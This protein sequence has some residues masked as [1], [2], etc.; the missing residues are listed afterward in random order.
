MEEE[1]RRIITQAVSAPL[2]L[3]DMALATFGVDFGVF[4]C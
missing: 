4:R 3:G 1:V 2:H